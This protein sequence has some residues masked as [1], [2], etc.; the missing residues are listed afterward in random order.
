MDISVIDKSQVKPFQPAQAYDGLPEISDISF[1]L[2]FLTITVYFQQIVKPV[3]IKFD[4]IRGFRV[5]DEGDLLEFWNPEL[6]ADGWLWIVEKGGWFDLESTRNG[7]VSGVT[8]GYSEFLI[9]GENECVS[10]ITEGSPE[11]YT[12]KH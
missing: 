3:Y 1:D 12:P 10:V 7:F 8:G 6:R 9:L 5:L 11:I 2:W 4:G